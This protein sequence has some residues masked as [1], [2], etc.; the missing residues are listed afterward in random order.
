M[1][2]TKW[3]SKCEGSLLE[4]KRKTQYGDYDDEGKLRKWKEHKMKKHK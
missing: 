4:E 1:N 2:L 3:L